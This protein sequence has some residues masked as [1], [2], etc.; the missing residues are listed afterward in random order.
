MHA[1]FLYL[2]YYA[3][4]PPSQRQKDEAA[5]K[6][7]RPPK[8]YES[9]NF[10]QVVPLSQLLFQVPIFPADLREDPLDATSF[11]LNRY[12]WGI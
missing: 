3:H 5:K 12:G 7:R 9:R 11:L 8:A 2:L 1:K 6:R 10:Y 4:L